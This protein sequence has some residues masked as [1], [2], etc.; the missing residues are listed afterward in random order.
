MKSPLPSACRRFLDEVVKQ[1]SRKSPDVGKL[2]RL[3]VLTMTEVPSM[4]ASTL[5]AQVERA[6]VMTFNLHDKGK[7]VEQALLL[8]IQHPDWSARRLAKAIGCEHTTLTRNR[9]F[10]M[11]KNAARRPLHGGYRVN[12]GVEAVVGKLPARGRSRRVKGIERTD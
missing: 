7:P 12:G 8:L 5:R 11:A 1:G 2:R 10:Q 9:R 6:I 4:P 3:A